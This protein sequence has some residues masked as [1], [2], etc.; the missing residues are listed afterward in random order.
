MKHP[1]LA[2]FFRSVR[3]S[4]SLSLSIVD[5]MIDD[6]LFYAGGSE[7][8]T[9]PPPLPPRRSFTNPPPLPPKWQP[10]SFTSSEKLPDLSSFT[11]RKILKI[12]CAVF[13]LSFARSCQRS[14][15]HCLFL[16]QVENP[17]EGCRGRDIEQ[18]LV[19]QI[20]SECFYGSTPSSPPSS[21]HLMTR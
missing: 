4:P 9:S 13:P 12:M 16:S 6:S 20:L 1:L 3:P 19:S 18:A 2:P 14:S 15:H 21:L 11:E 7:I 17:I 8:P 5:I 10:T